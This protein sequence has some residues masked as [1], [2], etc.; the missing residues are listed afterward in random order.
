MTL[1]N[2]PNFQKAIAF[3]LRKE[4]IIVLYV[5]LAIIAAGKQ[6]LHHSFNNYLIYKY[7]FWHTLDAENLYNQYPEYLDSNHYGPVFSLFVAPFALLPDG[8]GTLL[9]NLA[10]VAIFLWGVYS[11]PV[12]PNK[13]TIIAWICAHEALTA[14]FSF[15]FNIALTG[16]IILSFSYAV[17]KKE[18]QSAFFIALGTLIKLYGIVG[19]AFFFFTRNKFKFIIGGIAAFLVLFALPMAIS[20]PAFIVQS[21]SD[22]YQSLAHKNSLNASLTSFQDIS[23]MGMVRR[24]SGDVTIPNGPFL[25][26]GLLLFALPYIRIRQYKNLGFQLML[27]ASTLIFTVIFSSGSE[28][29][30]Y[31][32]AFAGVAIWFIV[33]PNPKSAW[34]IALFVF[35]F[36][37]T[38][39]SPTDIFPRTLKEFIRL[40]SLKA[41]PCVLIWLTLIYQMLKEDFGTYQITDK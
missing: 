17:K 11:L 2:K 8:L 35:A 22:W 15:Q 31:I 39:L 40:N 14:L 19:L 26:A 7:V 12:S 1:V 32:I 18:V 6:Y 13:R 5:L 25:L 10:N 33:Q 41:L 20:S 30:T 28:S 3:L 27:L 24:I 36:L 16:L 34:I 4:C 38:S 37:L 29:P 21:Y 23:L 9:W